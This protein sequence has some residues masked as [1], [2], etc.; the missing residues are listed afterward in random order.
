[1][2]RRIRGQLLDGLLQVLDE[3][4]LGMDR[5]GVVRFASA[6][7]ELLY[8]G[9]DLGLKVWE[10]LPSDPLTR[11]IS[12]CL[13][14]TDPESHEQVMAHHPEHLWLA[15]LDPVTGESGRYS[16]WL[17]RLKD[18]EPVERLSSR[19]EVLLGDVRRGLRDPLIALKSGLELLLEG[20]LGD[21]DLVIAILQ[22]LNEETNSLARLLLSL[23][24]P[25]Q[26]DTNLAASATVSIEAVTA[27]VMGTFEPLARGKNL[28]LKAPFDGDVPDLESV[29]ESE[30][31][32]C[33]VNLVDNA[34]KYTALHG[35]GEVKI[36][37]RV[38]HEGEPGVLISIDDSGPGIPK[39]EREAVFGQFYRLREGPTTRLG[40]TGLGLW[41]VNELMSKRRGKAWFEDSPLGGAGARLWFPL[42]GPA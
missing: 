33:L 18:I 3:P 20:D 27:K 14:S 24:P 34:V 23:D 30:L 26:E 9:L 21:Q 29:F 2:A 1:M 32:R 16:G 6:R 28:A 5:G 22:Q 36:T 4:V 7:F 35:Y 12:D 19:F 13:D 38:A 39:E 37:A 8:P 11:W 17:L 31:E 15:R 10:A 40:G 42:R 25:E 41:R